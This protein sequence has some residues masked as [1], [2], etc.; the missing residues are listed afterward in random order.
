MTFHCPKRH[1]EMLAYQFVAS[2][3]RAPMGHFYFLLGIDTKSPPYVLD[4]ESS[5]VGTV[6]CKI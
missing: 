2:E 6:A 3:S 5:L 1:A 4:N